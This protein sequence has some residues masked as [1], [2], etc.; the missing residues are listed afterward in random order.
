MVEHD[1]S[2]SLEVVRLSPRFEL[3][4][5]RGRGFTAGEQLSFHTQ[6]YQEAHDSQPKVDSNGDF[7]AV[8]TP[9]V[10]GRMMGTMEVTVRGKSCAPMLAFEWGS[11]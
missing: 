5:I 11:E 6:S 3:A 7:W 8:V 4:L 2:C 1:K 9:F 10:K